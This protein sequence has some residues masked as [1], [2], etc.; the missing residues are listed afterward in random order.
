MA[1]REFSERR[2]TPRVVLIVA[3]LVIIAVFLGLSRS[4]AGD[5]VPPLTSY[6]ANP[7]GSRGLMEVLHRLGWPVKRRT[8]PLRG[9]LDTAAVYL[10]L[11]PPLPLTTNEVRDLLGAVRNGASAVVVPRQHT[12]LADSLHLAQS[13]IS[14]RAYAAI[15]TTTLRDEPADSSATNARTSDDSAEAADADSDARITPSNTPLSVFWRYLGST[16]PIPSNAVTFVAVRD[17]DG[18]ARPVVLGVPLGRG[19][20]VAVAEPRIFS[21]EVVREGDAAVLDTR[22]IEWLTRS[23][24]TTLVFDEYHHGYGDHGSLRRAVGHAMLDTPPGRMLTQA[25]VAGLIL[26]AALG[27]RAIP[28]TPR[29]RVERRS[30]IEHAEALARAYEQV[31]ATRTASR[32]LLRGLRRRHAFGARASADDDAFLDAVRVRHPSLAE[33]VELVRDATRRPITPDAFLAVGLAIHHIDRTL[34]S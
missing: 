13:D 25:L 32:R 34:A 4:G 31:H 3:A 12:P 5:G 21:N 30:P 20:I 8:V 23:P 19:R 6:S 7:Y 28:P 16:A 27:I 22:L 18:R 14:M 1:D 26:L 10:V 2:L 11:A 24:R 29:S 9:R 33:D 17:H 15:D